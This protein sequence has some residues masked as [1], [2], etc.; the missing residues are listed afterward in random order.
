MKELFKLF[1][2]FVVAFRK[3]L[4]PLPVDLEQTLQEI[5]DYIKR[6]TK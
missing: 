2:A 1:D 6:N 4:G 5:R 3:Y